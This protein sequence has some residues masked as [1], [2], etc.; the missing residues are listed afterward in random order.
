MTEVVTNVLKG[1][2]IPRFKTFYTKEK[3]SSCE[4]CMPVYETESTAATTERFS[5]I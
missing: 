1:R 4:E 3:S 5:K 2:N